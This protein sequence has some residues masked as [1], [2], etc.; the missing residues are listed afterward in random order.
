MR[1][2]RIAGPLVA[3]VLA[4]AMT[5]S[6]IGTATAAPP[7]DPGPS[8]STTGSASAYLAGPVTG[9]GVFLDAFTPPGETSFARVEIFVAGYEC[10]TDESI[11]AELDGLDFASA[12][13]QL[14]LTCGSSQ[15]EITGYADV[16]VA[17]EGTGRIT[18]TTLAGHGRACLVR[19]QAREAT[20]TGTVEVT[21]PGLGIQ[22]TAVPE[23]GELRQATE[24]CP[25][26]R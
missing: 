21:I 4:A 25:P 23:S 8:R 10:L 19:I 3:G 2:R 13:G 5:W 24:H 20:V 6:G 26:R 12:Q 11:P 9:L 17:W 15:G 7:P 1:T 18:R 14:T 16:D 22:E